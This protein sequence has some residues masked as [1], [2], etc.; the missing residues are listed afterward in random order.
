[1][2]EEFGS[3]YYWTVKNIV[4][5]EDVNAQHPVKNK[6]DMHLSRI[7]KRYGTTPKELCKGLLT[8]GDTLGT[9]SYVLRTGARYG[10]FTLA[11]EKELG[12]NKPSPSTAR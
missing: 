7:A 11:K 6:R 5:T 12:G 2:K 8:T 10:V 9:I 3:W 1:M 4:M